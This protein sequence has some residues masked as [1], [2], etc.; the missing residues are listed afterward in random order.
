MLL[1]NCSKLVDLDVHGTYITAETLHGVTTFPRVWFSFYLVPFY[2][3][4]I[5]FSVACRWK[6]GLNVKG[7]TTP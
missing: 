5:F 3:V 2:L 4:K 1:K 7:M 6:G